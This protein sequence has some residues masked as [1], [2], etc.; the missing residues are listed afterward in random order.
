MLLRED[1]SV[2]KALEIKIFFRSSTLIINGE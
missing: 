2:L 1:A